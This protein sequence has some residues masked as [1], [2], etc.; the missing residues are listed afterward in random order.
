MKVKTLAINGLIAALYFALAMLIKPLAYGPI[1]YRLPEI[2]NHLVVFNKK[3]AIGI[4]LGVLIANLFSPLGIY[5]LFFGL[6]Q[7]IIALATTIFCGR[8]VKNKMTLMI[9]NMLVF[10]FTM[11]MIAWEIHIFYKAPFWESWLFCAVGELVVMGI[12]IP[13][14]L[15]LNKR[16]HFGKA[17]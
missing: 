3:Y 4:A 13:V 10:T 1:Q 16:L 7:T 8:F 14:M 17:F 12:G 15:F 2:F 11:F 9:I 6:P 5:E